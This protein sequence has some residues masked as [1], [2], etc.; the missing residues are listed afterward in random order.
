[1]QQAAQGHI[2]I[3]LLGGSVVEGNVSALGSDYVQVSPGLSITPT[4]K[5]CIPFTAINYIDL[6]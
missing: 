3:V 5:K 6:G 1:M 2:K 4:T